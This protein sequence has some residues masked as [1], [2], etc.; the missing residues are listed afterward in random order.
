VAVVLILAVSNRDALKFY[1]KHHYTSGLAN[2]V[3]TFGA[4]ALIDG[5]FE[6]VACCSFGQPISENLRAS[7]FGV[8]H[9]DRVKELQ[10]LARS[11]EC[12]FTMSSFVSKSIKLY[13]QSRSQ[14]LLPELWCIISFADSVQSHHGGV[15]QAMS[16]LYCGSSTSIV[17]TFKDQ[18]GRS[19]HRRQNGVNITK[20]QAIARGW[21]HSKVKTTKHRYI[22]ILGTSK[23]RR[24]RLNALQLKAEPYP[25][26]ERG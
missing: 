10:R 19:R 23:Q 7:I 21:S 13:Q 2:N 12:P 9:V 18:S 1:Q 3:L 25:K 17:D 8:E 26:P 15:Y 22:K 20:Q 16:W 11:P 4:Y 14:K 24:Q 5:N 6:L